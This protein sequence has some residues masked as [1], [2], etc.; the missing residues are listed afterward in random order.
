MSNIGNL[1]AY[2]GMD[3][4][5]MN[6]DMIKGQSML[7][8]FA[9]SGT[10]SI[11]AVTAA[12]G[13]LSG[14]FAALGVSIGG[15]MLLKS[16]DDI[17]T[18]FEQTMAIVGG[19][20]RAT[21]EEME[22]LT[23]AAREMGEKTDWT[24]SQAGESLKFLGMAGFDAGKAIEALPGT[25]DLA[26]AGTLDLGR[27]A[28]IA[29]NALTAMQLPVKDLGR[30]N[31]VFVGTITRSNVNM[32]EMAEAFKYGAPVANA[33]GYSIEELS[34][35]IGT[36]GN[37]GIKG[38]MAG[39]QLAMAIQQANEV[40]G[41]FG[42]SSSDLL[43]VLESMQKEGR[44]NAD[45]MQLFGMR[46][47]RAA[48]I[49]KDMIQPARDLQ[50]TLGGVGGE[51]KT[52]ADTM[53]G[54]IGGAKKELASVF[55]SIKIDIFETFRD[56]LKSSIEN[57]T[58]WLRENKDDIIAFAKGVVDAVKSIGAGVKDIWDILSGFVEGVENV[59]DGIIL[60]SGDAVK[61]LDEDAQAMRDYLNPPELTEWEQFANTW[62][63]IGNHI[64]EGIK[65]L[66]VVVGNLLGTMINDLASTISTALASIWNAADAVVKVLNR[67]F[68]GAGKSIEQIGTDLEAWWNDI[69]E[70]GAEMA[71]N[72]GNA[73]DDMVNNLSGKIKLPDFTA[74]ARARAEAFGSVLVGEESPP[75]HTGKDVTG[76]TTGEED[77][78][79]QTA[80]GKMVDVQVAA[81]RDMLS[82]AGR[83]K[84]QLADIWEAYSESR[85]EQI[86][87]EAAEM[88]AAGVSL[89]TVAA[90][91]RKKMRDLDR[92][93]RELF[94]S[95]DNSAVI[96]AQVQLYR[97]LL[98]ETDTTKEQ[99]LD[100]WDDY[101]K[102]RIEQ[103]NREAKGLELIGLSSE[104]IV[105]FVSKQMR[106][107]DREQRR[108][109]EAQG[110]WLRDFMRN[111][112]EDLGQIMNEFFFDVMAGD[113]KK[114]TDYMESIWNAFLRRIANKATGEF[115][116]LIGLGEKAQGGKGFDL[117]SFLGIGGG[118]K[119]GGIPGFDY[120]KLAGMIPAF[121]TGGVV[122]SP[123]IA[124]IGE[125]PEAV[126][127]L[128][129]LRDDDFM[130][131]LGSDR[132]RQEAP[133][134]VTFNIQTPDVASFRRSEQQ[135][136]TQA[137]V[138]IRQARRNM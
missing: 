28:D 84:E 65:F 100:I 127:P 99:L 97:D 77:K 79:A 64:V 50:E 38:S 49:L 95:I 102:S 117:L 114:L 130:R 92:E 57:M 74:M 131:S 83:T 40:A 25:L 31:D 10:K 5:G 46:A 105:R 58:K 1:T 86:W 6:R 88:K 32:E 116:D 36:L 47:G 110:R 133:V 93:Q 81:Y 44:T 101:E 104:D 55:E 7:R 63:E 85:K 75:V 66:A 54:T 9:S 103:I 87:V 42:Y 121:A 39:T 14:A 12:V 69:S 124:Q 80:Y 51:A 107:L 91:V 113:F 21:R 108:M 106:D 20:M 76:T 16:V 53:R 27:A 119:S 35:M 30:V 48:L 115:M 72:I 89:G 68:A 22:A 45:I 56:D 125:V 70:S 13:K 2:L 8:A 18:Q 67:D 43:D 98:S 61:E 94:T 112:A 118:A 135:I 19:V 17:G 41:K 109:F 71:E 73:W 33:F 37:A 4:M 59:F 120:S 126:I 29:T 11:G 90:T 132:E 34:G 137:A 52:L 82:E 136:M 129:K 134:N 24:A 111:L 138:A 128:A 78:S 123:T 15:V 122:S 23:A 62:V 96:D 60:K 3:T 26:T